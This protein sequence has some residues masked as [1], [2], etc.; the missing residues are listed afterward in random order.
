L[1]VRRFYA[2]YG[3]PLYYRDKGGSGRGISAQ[4]TRAIAKAF[5]EI[6]NSLKKRISS[7]GISALKTLA[8][9][10]QEIPNNV[11]SEAK[12]A[13]LALQDCKCL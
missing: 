4:A 13:L 3:I 7:V 12:E 5:A 9:F 1:L 8:V 11:E 6:H 10:E 2:A